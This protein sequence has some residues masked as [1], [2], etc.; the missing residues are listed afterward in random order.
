MILFVLKELSAKWCTESKEGR[1]VRFLP[2]RIN[3]R[4]NSKTGTSVGDTEDSQWAGLS[5]GI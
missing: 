4:V 2:P 3:R 5:S 1:T